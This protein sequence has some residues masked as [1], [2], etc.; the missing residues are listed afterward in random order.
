[1]RLFVPPPKGSGFYSMSDSWWY[2]LCTPHPLTTL[3]FAFLSFLE[4]SPSSSP[5][6][7]NYVLTGQACLPPSP[8]LT[9]FSPLV[10]FSGFF[11]ASCHTTANSWNSCPPLASN[12][13]LQEGDEAAENNN[14]IKDKPYRVTLHLKYIYNIAL[15]TCLSANRV[16]PGKLQCFII[17]KVLVSCSDLSCVFCRSVNFQFLEYCGCEVSISHRL[18]SECFSLTVGD[19][20]PQISRI[21]LLKFLHFFL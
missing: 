2:F 4:S 9:S 14:K 10:F 21:S 5:P 8:P 1:M 18:R 20:I 11:Q 6:L 17:F 15:P 7:R 19:S 13:R 12:K 16:P 3:S